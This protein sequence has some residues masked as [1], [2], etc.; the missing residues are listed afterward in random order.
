MWECEERKQKLRIRRRLD[1]FEGEKKTPTSRKIAGWSR[2][3]NTL[4]KRIPTD[5]EV[6]GKKGLILASPVPELMWVSCGGRRAQSSN[7]E[8]SAQRW[9]S[10]TTVAEMALWKIWDGL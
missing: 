1:G 4:D 6:R 10:K 7:F 8:T 9:S 5:S 3:E 2:N